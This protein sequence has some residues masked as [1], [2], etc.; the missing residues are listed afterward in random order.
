MLTRL[1]P[2]V[3]YSAE[4]T[5]SHI[6]F[7]L[8][9]LAISF[10]LFAFL[11]DG[12][13]NSFDGLIKIIFSRDALIT[14]YIE[15]AGI[16]G[17]F[18]NAGIVMLITI[19]LFYFSKIPFFGVTTASVLLM[20]GFALFGKN[21]FNIL[22]I[23][24]GGFLYTKINDEEF[25]SYAYAVVFGTTLAPIV[26]EVGYLFNIDPI[27]KIPL[28]ILI[29]VLIGYVIPPVSAHTVRAHQGYNL[30]NV[31]MAAGLIGMIAVSLFKSFG[32][33]FSS[34]NLWSTSYQTELIIFFSLIFG[35]MFLY[36][37]YL[38]S[39]SFKGMKHFTKHSGRAVADY[40]VLEG[41]PRTLINMGLLGFMSMGYVLIIGSHL[42]GPSL[43][44]ILTVVGFG[45]FGKHI[46]NV[47]PLVL[48]VVLASFVMKWNLSDPS[49]VLAALFATGLSPIA[50]QFGFT[51]G[52]ITGI[53]HAAVV[54]EVGVLHGWLNLYNNGFAA[55]LICI[56][57]VP[58]IEAHRSSN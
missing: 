29:G 54:R 35:F 15:V 6:D 18:L 7:L 52:L 30:Y 48:G 38:N 26:G 49:M 40:I 16:G 51:W 10:C 57:I 8:T 39:Y 13:S 34:N 44:G 45:A 11:I 56:V 42:N 37:F 21:V 36:G 32:Y 9:M 20:G 43:G 27:I 47:I 58:I 50:G 12:I 22:P 46:K 41:L 3:K 53:I 31:G 25:A 19:I 55:G 14:D 5:S 28:M 17:A 24:F 2:K 23:M 1:K 33:E 4:N